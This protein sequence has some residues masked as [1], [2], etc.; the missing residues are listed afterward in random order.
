MYE[1]SLA[2]PDN[3]YHCDS[4]D[5]EFKMNVIRLVVSPYV[6]ESFLLGLAT[7]SGFN[8]IN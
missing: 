4:V 3:Q 1:K 2:L 5:N 7:L 8:S 6:I